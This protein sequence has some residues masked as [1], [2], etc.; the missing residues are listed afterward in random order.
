MHLLSGGCDAGNRF[1]MQEIIPFPYA[2]LP[3]KSLLCPAYSVEKD[4][5]V[6]YH[7]VEQSI[8]PYMRFAEKVFK[9]YYTCAVMAGVIHSL[10]VIR[11]KIPLLL[12]V[13][14][15]AYRSYTGGLF[16]DCPSVCAAHEAYDSIM[17]ADSLWKGGDFLVGLARSERQIPVLDV[18]AFSVLRPWTQSQAI[19]SFAFKAP[20]GCIPA[21]I[22]GRKVADEVFVLAE[23]LEK[24]RQ[25]TSSL[26]QFFAFGHKVFDV[27][28]TDPLFAWYPTNTFYR[29]PE[30]PALF[31][32]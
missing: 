6:S 16:A 17:S 32:R 23:H 5:T 27:G 10:Y 2:L 18:L 11:E 24:G 8:L 3:E 20:M 14:A 19:E 15:S 31:G 28:F 1:L 25:R 22:E 26:S 12:Y 7:L 30:L 29:V 9:D 4:E 13:H 21:F